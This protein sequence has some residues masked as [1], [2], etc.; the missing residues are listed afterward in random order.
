MRVILVFRIAFRYF[1]SKTTDRAVSVVSWCSILGILIG[2]FSLIVVSSVMRGFKEE[3][4]ASIVSLNGEMKITNKG[5]LYNYREILDKLRALDFVSSTSPVSS[6]YG[7]A[8]SSFSHV[9]IIVRNIAASTPKLFQG[10]LSELDSENSIAISKSMSSAL[11]IKINDK[12]TIAGFTDVTKNKDVTVKAIFFDSGVDAWVALVPF[13][14]AKSFTGK[15]DCA[16]YIEVCTKIPDRIDFY[17]NK[18]KKDILTPGYS[19]LTWKD[20][21]PELMK[22]IATEGVAMFVVLGLIILVATFSVFSNL[23]V[24][25]RGRMREISIL[26]TMGFSKSSIMSVFIIF[27]MLSGFIGSSIGMFLSW[28][29]LYNANYIKSI[30]AKFIH[31]RIMEMIFYFLDRLPVSM[32]YMDYAYVSFFTLALAFISTLYPS[33]KAAQMCPSDVL[34]SD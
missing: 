23:F 20:S 11:A 27:G 25:V 7:L 19:I 16:S 9:P 6:C 30:C 26:K 3:L 5:G 10:D 24:V 13:S 2:V 31:I 28:C 33:Y 15:G 34:Y 4:I 14:F 29:F 17:A 22:A 8:V 18:I 12:F 1:F 32:N 21:N